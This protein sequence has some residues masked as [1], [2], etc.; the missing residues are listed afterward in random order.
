MNPA[1]SN[2][3][4]L[5]AT[6]AFGVEASVKWELRRLGYEPSV[7]AT[8]RVS[9]SAGPRAIVRSNLWL[10][11][12]DRVLLV[13]KRAEAS[14]FD[15]LFAAVRS[16]DWATWL[17]E[18]AK[19]NVRVGI[20]RSPM[21]SP[22]SAQS[23]V[24]RAIVE[25][26][27][28]PGQMLDESGEEVAVDVSVL[29][30]DVTIALDTSGQG[31]HKRGY[32]RQTRPGQLKETLAAAML[33]TCRYRRGQPLIDPFCGSGTIAIEAALMASNRAPGAGRT[34]DAERW[35]W[36]DP[37]LW[38]D[39]RE[40]ADSGIDESGMAPILASDIN[41]QA[42]GL[43]RT[44]AQNA[45]VAHLID[46]ELRDY[47]ELSSDLEGGWVISNPPYGE[48]VGEKADAERIQRD[49]PDV[50]SRL[51][52][53]S[54]GL[55]LGGDSFEQI[56]G[57]SASRRRKLYN[58]K[59]RCTLYQ[60]EPSGEKAAAFE[61]QV[62]PEVLQA[63][64]V[65][66]EKMV[67]HT[68][69]WP[70]KQDIHAYRLFEGDVQGRR[71]AVDRYAESLRVELVSDR[72]PSAQEMNLLDAVADEAARVVGV[73]ADNAFRV[74]PALSPARSTPTVV[75]RERGVLF[76]TK[77]GA[78]GLTGFEPALRELR[79]WVRRRAEGAT[80]LDL[81]AGPGAL[82]EIAAQSSASL[83]S[84]T[85]DGQEKAWV[86]RNLKHN[87]IGPDRAEFAPGGDGALE[88]D[89]QFALIVGV[90]D[91][92]PSESV[93]EQ[94]D[95]HLAPGGSAVIACPV[96]SIP[97]GDIPDL[98]GQSRELTRSLTPED[99][100]ASMPWRIFSCRTPAD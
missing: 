56:I 45:G 32:R 18:G 40:R 55:L 62:S 15:D 34:F 10:R 81:C 52:T 19:I 3:L 98:P 44:C 72:R 9:Y 1:E 88:S 67:R 29:G 83:L 92:P 20:V 43:A 6:A 27:V 76:E 54:F 91:G 100:R 77:P 2:D 47:R 26:I 53:W 25:S 28:G 22:R 68:R 14:D 86:L 87:R 48:R 96:G 39:E 50:L 70:E 37:A 16:I 90:F 5:I 84:L 85:D 71:M 74:S 46:I 7:S 21:K 30:T 75:V 36:I 79:E 94:I 89:A 60:F 13:L 82:T 4:E 61:S 63:F 38:N 11:G 51:P 31:L 35:P 42:V 73:P 78:P 95:D 59:I 23:V 24:K 99:F 97:E 80:V 64:R 58:A 8:G 66:L 65:S 93:L 41:P 49:L 12:A 69:K 17:P 33:M 57:R